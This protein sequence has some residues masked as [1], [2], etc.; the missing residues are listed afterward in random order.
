MGSVLETGGNS[1]QAPVPLSQQQQRDESVAR[2]VW[3]FN[4]NCLLE[5]AFPLDPFKGGE[6]NTSGLGNVHHVQGQTLWAKGPISVLRCSVFMFT[7]DKKTALKQELVRAKATV[8]ATCALEFSSDMAV[9]LMV[10][11]GF[12]PTL[13]GKL[14]C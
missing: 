13:L 1:S 6:V 10:F 8:T 12:Y 9:I 7:V 4:I 5:A 11:K 2:L 3:I 14:S